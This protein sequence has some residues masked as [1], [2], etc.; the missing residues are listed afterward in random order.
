MIRKQLFFLIL[1]MPEKKQ[2]YEMVECGI[3]KLWI[4]GELKAR[5]HHAMSLLA[6]SRLNMR[7]WAFITFPFQSPVRHDNFSK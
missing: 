4:F 1:Q 3:E 5:V 6:K 7:V 2:Q